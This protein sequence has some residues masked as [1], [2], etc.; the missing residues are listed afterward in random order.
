METTLDQITHWN[1]SYHFSFLKN[2]KEVNANEILLMVSP[3]WPSKYFS[4]ASFVAPQLLLCSF[5]F[6][7]T[8]RCHEGHGRRPLRS[9]GRRHCS[10]RLSGNGNRL[11]LSLRPSVEVAAFTFTNSVYWSCA[12]LTINKGY[13]QGWAVFWIGVGPFV[14]AL[15]FSVTKNLF[16]N[17]KDGIWIAFKFKV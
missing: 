9:R 1:P 13:L 5:C 8:Q 6:T 4:K 2:V 11:R 14:V 15:E 10:V 12:M 16:K 7:I 17:T 3:K